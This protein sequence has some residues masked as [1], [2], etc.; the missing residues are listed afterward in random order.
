[1]R[2]DTG[3]VVRWFDRQISGQIRW[4]ADLKSVI[5]IESGKGTNLWQQP[6]D[7]GAPQPLTDFD[8]QQISAFDISTDGRTIVL[9]R[10][11]SSFEAILLE[12]F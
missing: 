1:M 9:S 12:N 2:A 4:A 6:I 5:F 3:E 11:S 8:T 7:G 10:G